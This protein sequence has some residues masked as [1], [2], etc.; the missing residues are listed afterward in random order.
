M[1]FA[2]SCKRFSRK[3]PGPGAHRLAGRPI[4]YYQCLTL[5][6]A[7]RQNPALYLLHFPTPEVR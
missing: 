4:P 1:A 7:D 5:V 3:S 6:M 2:Q